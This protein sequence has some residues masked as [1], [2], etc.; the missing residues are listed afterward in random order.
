MKFRRGRLG[1]FVWILVLGL[2]SGVAQAEPIVVSN[3]LATVEGNSNNAIPFSL[4][5]ISMRY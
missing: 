5:G 1:V 3:S 4:F 2:L